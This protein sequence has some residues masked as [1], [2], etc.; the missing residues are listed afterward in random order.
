MGRS[1]RLHEFDGTTG[2]AL[3][4]EG[5]HRFGNV[6]AGHSSIRSRGVSEGECR[7]A[8]AAT[9]I[10]HPLPRLD[11]RKRE[12]RLADR[13]ERAVEALLCFGPA[14]TSGSVPIV[15]L[16]LVAAHGAILL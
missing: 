3:A 7:R 13:G 1:I 15:D 6:E 11:R 4:R 16:V 8:A 10:E 5:E 14:L 12:E 2:S 9:D